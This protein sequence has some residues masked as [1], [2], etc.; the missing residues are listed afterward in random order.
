MTINNGKTLG[1][2]GFFTRPSSAVK[3]FATGSLEYALFAQDQLALRIPLID[4]SAVYISRRIND[5][6]LFRCGSWTQQPITSIEEYGSVVDGIKDKKVDNKTYLEAQQSMLTKHLDADYLKII[7]DVFLPEDEERS[8]RANKKMEFESNMPK[9]VFQNLILSGFHPDLHKDSNLFESQ[10]KKLNKEAQEKIGNSEEYAAYIGS[11]DKMVGSILDERETKTK[12]PVLLYK[13]QNINPEVGQ[14]IDTKISKGT[15]QTRNS[16]DNNIWK[17][18]MDS[19]EEIF[20][21]E[22]T[23]EKGKIKEEIKNGC[24]GNINISELSTIVL[25]KLGLV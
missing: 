21:E 3:N 20:E 22:H 16:W 2:I 19:F 17:E 8:Y 4:Q 10:F 23:T 6:A 7:G 18:A 15:I 13:S 24:Y 5:R 1:D 14:I 9:E 11:L 12:T 25:Q